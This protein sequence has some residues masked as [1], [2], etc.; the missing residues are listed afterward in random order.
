[1]GSPLSPV[2]ANFYMEDFEK[3][4][5]E[6]ATHKPVCWF[7]YLEDAFVI[8][9]HSLEKLTISDPPQWIWHEYSV[10]NAKKN[11]KASFHFWILTLQKTG[12]LRRSH[13]SEANP[14]QCLTTPGFISLP[15]TKQSVLVPLIHQAKALFDQDSLT[16]GLGFLTNC[17]RENG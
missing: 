10:H 12:R 3:K 1:M 2:I 6:Q 4:V 16:Q 8:W 17:F 15:C 7:R 13:L 11:K 14:Y 9:P 5:P